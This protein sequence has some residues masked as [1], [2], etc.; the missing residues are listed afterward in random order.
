M[1]EACLDTMKIHS[2]RSSGGDHIFKRIYV[3][4]DGNTSLMDKTLSAVS[5]ENPSDNF[6]LDFIGV[7]YSSNSERKIRRFL[8]DV[9]VERY[10]NAL[11]TMNRL[12]FPEPPLPADSL[13]YSTTAPTDTLLHGGNYLYAHHTDVY[14][15]LPVLSNTRWLVEDRGSIWLDLNMWVGGNRLES[16][17]LWSSVSLVDR[18]L[19]TALF[20]NYL[21][22]ISYDRVLEICIGHGSVAPAILSLYGFRDYILTGV[23]ETGEPGSVYIE[24]IK[25]MYPQY[26]VSWLST[27]EAGPSD[28]S[29]VTLDTNQVA[30]WV[31]EQYSSR[32]LRHSPRG[33]VLLRKASNRGGQGQ[34]DALKLL[35]DLHSVH[36]TV[37]MHPPPYFGMYYILEWAVGDYNTE[38]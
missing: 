31:N 20:K 18:L 19:R 4:L 5:I 34:L 26:M 22:N 7:F 30:H 14:D 15:L 6:E 28:V 16:A 36:T 23:T 11:H 24:N 1:I 8:V 21:G 12:L 10:S 32:Y 25:R 3:H 17:W 33:V 2:Y 27:E 13:E 9:I 29:L 37:I 35:S 38:L